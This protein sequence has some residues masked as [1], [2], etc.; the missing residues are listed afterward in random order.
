[1]GEVLVDVA[2]ANKCSTPLPTRSTAPFHNASMAE[3]KNHP[4]EESVDE[5]LEGVPDPTRKADAQAL[6]RLLEEVTGET[7][8]M[9]GDSMVGFGTQ[10]LH[11]ASGRELDWFRVGFSPRKQSLTIYLPEGFSDHEELL[12]QLGPHTTGKGCLYVK[13][14]AEIDQEALRRLLAAVTG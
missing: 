10:H 14:L 9:W 11:Y 8:Q 5:F 1:M 2:L 7:P 6:R 4:T 13:R 3:L 12:S